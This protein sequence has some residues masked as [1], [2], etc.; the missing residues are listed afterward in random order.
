MIVFDLASP[1]PH[2]L[3]QTDVKRLGKILG[4]ALRTRKSRA[5]G[6]RFVPPRVMRG[7]NRTYRG[8][9][10]PTDVLSFSSAA[11]PVATGSLGDLAV[12]PSYARHEAQ[13]RGVDVREEL[14]RLLAHGTLH[15][16]GY[17]HCTKQQE[18]RMFALQERCVKEIMYPLP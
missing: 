2:S 13:Q 18:R 10:R 12:C 14:L 15:L 4:K 6:V 11:L 3:T 1:L 16:F 5:I 17:D 9:N 8:I 7:L